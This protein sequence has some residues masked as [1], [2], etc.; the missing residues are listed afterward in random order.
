AIYG[1]QGANGVVVVTTK[2]AKAGVTN[3]NVSTR[4]GFNQLTNGNLKVM[5]GEELYDY[6]AAFANANEI[7]FQRWKPELWNSNFDWS[8]LATQ[9]GCVQNN[10][11]LISSGTEELRSFLSVSMYDVKGAVKGYHYRRYN[12]RLNQEYKLFEWLTI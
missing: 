6:Y 9:S 2:R 4:M 3:I 1:S 7:T 5:N 8:D 10:N 11:V 12:V